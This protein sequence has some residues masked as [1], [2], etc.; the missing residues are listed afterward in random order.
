M[1]NDIFGISGLEKKLRMAS[2]MNYRGYAD[3][4]IS[5]FE[6]PSELCLLFFSLDFSTDCIIEYASG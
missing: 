1:F 6:F 3:K 5:I 4:A 2:L